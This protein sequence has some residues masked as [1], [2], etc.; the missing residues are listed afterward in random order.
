MKK[1]RSNNARKEGGILLIVMLI[2]LLL[3]FLSVGFLRLGQVD[4]L[5]TSGQLNHARAFW[6]AEAGLNELKAII[7]FDDN[8]RPLER[9]GLVG[10][11]T[12]VLSRTI[13][14][15]GSYE[16]FVRAVAAEN[17]LD[18][19]AHYAIE[20]VGRSPGGAAS[21]VVHSLV[22]LATVAEEVWMTHS[23]GNVSFA[24][25]DKLYGPTKTNGKF[26]IRGTPKIYGRA[27]TGS[28]R[29][30]YNDS[31][32]TSVADPDVFLEGLSFGVPETDFDSDLIDDIAGQSGMA[33]V[34]GPAAIEFLADGRYVLT[35]DEITPAVTRMEWQ[36][37]H[38][39]RNG[40]R[41]RY[42]PAGYVE[43]VVEPERRTSLST[44]NHID[45]IGMPEIDDNIIYVNGDV[46]VK[47]EVGGSVS[48]VSDGTISIVDNI[49]Y[50]SAPA[51]DSSGAPSIPIEQWAARDIEPG[52]DERLGLYAK[53]KV[54]VDFPDH[55]SG[56]EGRPVNIH[57]AIFVTEPPGGVSNA[58]FGTADRGSY[59]GLPYIH[60]FGSIVQYDRG[61]IGYSGGKGFLKDYH[62][63]ARFMFSPAPG[64]P[65][66]VPV[67]KN[68]R[69]EYR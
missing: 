8:R 28:S 63:D 67:F 1:L 33:P 36:R 40:R 29:V 47:G 10:D 68:W 62:H 46:S 60:L 2:M 37:A 30:N 12:A 14:G 24:D 48:V 23:E 7:T 18:E 17:A 41:W 34:E 43:V 58:G 52:S 57:A 53:E 65:S 45:N 31:R 54:E 59:L 32:T 20:V 56:N 21:V 25:G 6:M 11:D 5:E 15:S 16:V 35:E 61:T 64:S 39:E 19:S 51:L 27:S 26:N 3:A 44:T 9:Y 42:V 55:R 69:M 50:A 66:T 38:W 13:D 4:M 49:V 22:R